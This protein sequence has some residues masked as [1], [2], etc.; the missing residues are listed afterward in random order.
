MNINRL[1]KLELLS[2]LDSTLI[3]VVAVSIVVAHLVVPITLQSVYVGT[4]TFISAICMAAIFLLCVIQ[5]CA[6][7][8]VFIKKFV[9]RFKM[10]SIFLASLAIFAACALVSN[11]LIAE[12]LQRAVETD[13]FSFVFLAICL[14]LAYFF[15]RR[16]HKN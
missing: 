1:S 6:L 13:I 8:I 15:W 7:S 5:I 10:L 11:F 9:F 3:A 12:S 2:F 14:P 16:D 4:L